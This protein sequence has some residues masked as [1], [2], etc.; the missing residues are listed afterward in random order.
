M[1][2]SSLRIVS[3]KNTPPE[4]AEEDILQLDDAV[5]ENDQSDDPEKQMGELRR[6]LMEPEQLQISNILER[7]NNPRIRSREMSRSLTEA[8]RMRLADDDSL[9]DAL[10]PTITIAFQNSIK[11][12]PGPVA[13]AIS[14]LMGPAIRHAIAVALSSLVQSLD[15][16]LKH[17]LSWQGLKWRIEA[18][19]TGKSFAEV[20]LYHTLVYRVEQVFLI[21]K[22]TGLL[23]HHINAD[24]SVSQDADIVSGMLTAIQVANSNFARDS[25]GSSEDQ[26]DTLDFG[27]RQVWLESGPHAVLAVVIRGDAPESL[28]ADFF[29]PAIEAI[30]I[31]QRE[32]LDPFNGDPAPFEDTRRHLETCLRSQ[33]QGRTDPSQ[34]KIP[35]YVWLLLGVAIIALGIWGIFAWRDARRWNAY[36]DRLKTEPGIVVAETGKQDGKRYVSGLRD[37]M[38]ADPA[39]ILRRETTID[40]ASVISRWEAYQALDPKFVLARAKNLLEPPSSVELK[41]ENGTLLAAGAAPHEWINEA[42]RIS[43]VLPGVNKFDVD[44]LLNEDL[45]RLRRQ[46]EQ[47]VILFVMGGAQIA[48]GQQK[49]FQALIADVQQLSTLAPA[50]GRSFR[51]EIIGHTDT[52]GNDSLNLTLSR[53]RAERV[54]SLLLSN[55]ISNDSLTAIG[56]GST[57]PVKPET[58][59]NDKE[60]NRSVTFK[61]S[62]PELRQQKFP[63]TEEQRR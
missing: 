56:V 17:S 43:R 61:V 35:A 45:D 4:T 59:A 1:S 12:D 23:L 58:S 7:L 20:V 60:F 36:L 53:S 21:H 29:A 15:Q 57:Q 13:K 46:I 16:T 47:Q 18:L 6:L 44:N 63:P 26:I 41:F 39:E 51:I 2:D 27:D 34:F 5:P 31:E 50:A 22:Q 62:L 42:R 37:P 49:I 28:R 8:V 54:M 32:L 19:R 48:P 33:Y 3:S 11:K 30:H 52:E 40:P 14:P 38:A 25:F 55:R 10:E 24:E 9:N